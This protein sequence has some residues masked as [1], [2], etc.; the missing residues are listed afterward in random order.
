[1]AVL[2]PELQFH[3]LEFTSW[4]QEPIIRQVCSSWRYFIDQSQTQLLKRYTDIRS[5]SSSASFSY[6]GI[7]NAVNHKSYFVQDEKSKRFRHWRTNLT[8]HGL[9]Y[10]I[11]YDDI[12]DIDWRENRTFETNKLKLFLN[13]HIFKIYDP[14][15]AKPQGA[16]DLP[17]P[18]L[19]N[20][21]D[22]VSIVIYGV[23]P[24]HVVRF[25]RPSPLHWKSTV[26]EFF[27]VILA[28]LNEE[29]L[30]DDLRQAEDAT[31]TYV[32]LSTN[33]TMAY[34]N[35]EGLGIKISL[36]FGVR[37]DESESRISER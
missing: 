20:T 12:N 34:Y 22:P 26:G 16:V 32:K 2:P 33:A 10:P 15:A 23:G 18:G 6:A 13:D 25:T 30:R 8:T 36:I 4:D 17:Q 1:M 28:I 3:I 7:H 31:Y 24:R 19:K 27:E 37:V 11:V 29:D 9:Q 21:F 5:G 14:P 35:G